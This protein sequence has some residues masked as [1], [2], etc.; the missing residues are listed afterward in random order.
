MKERVKKWFEKLK[1]RHALGGFIAFGVLFLIIILFVANYNSNQDSWFNNVVTISDFLTSIFLV[2]SLIVA[3]GIYLTNRNII[4]ANQAIEV[5]KKMPEYIPFKHTLIEYLIPLIKKRHRVVVL[6]NDVDRE[7]YQSI[8][9]QI[10]AYNDYINYE[11]KDFFKDM[12]EFYLVQKDDKNEASLREFFLRECR[13]EYYDYIVI[14]TVS[15]IFSEAILARDKMD[16]CYK[17]SIK[18]IGTLTSISKKI[19]RYVNADNDIIRVFPP[20]YDEAKSAMSFLLARL[21]NRV[22][23]NTNCSFILERTNVVVL[24]NRTYGKAVAKQSKY[25]FD[26]ELESFEITLP[27]SLKENRKDRMVINFISAEF[28]INRKHLKINREDTTLKDLPKDVILEDIMGDL[29]G[30]KNYFYIV[31]YE[32]NISKMLIRLN[33]I[34]DSKT[35]HTI[36]IC[37]TATMRF[38]RESILKT[39][40]SCENLN[41][42]AFYLELD[43]YSVNG[44]T[45]SLESIDLNIKKGID[46]NDEYIDI[47]TEI[48]KNKPNS[49]NIVKLLSNSQNYIS[50]YTKTSL[51]IAKYS[52]INRESLLYSKKRVLEKRAS[53]DV[54]MELLVNGDS[55]NKYRA[56]ELL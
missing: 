26:K 47:A 41:K 45:H 27:K 37:G 1:K 50:V 11:H 38:W 46:A 19:N 40:K 35:Q 55:I 7:N 48:Y 3:F 24:Y 34:I 29:S 42:E 10:V 23:S 30:A 21:H 36:L 32:P 6:L 25:F 22:C 8:A 17:K 13:V 4:P 18:I 14:A 5:I 33:S 54:K 43:S 2:L 31:G 44:N 53:V 9:S 49:M 39:L 15:S 51:D 20:D 12:T 28:N 52:I 16:E 56:K